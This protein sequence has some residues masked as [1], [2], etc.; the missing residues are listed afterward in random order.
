MQRKEIIGLNKK[1]FGRCNIFADQLQPGDLVRLAESL[2]FQVNKYKC[3]HPQT[4][5][6][7]ASW[8]NK[9]FSCN[10]HA[11][12]TPDSSSDNLEQGAARLRANWENLGEQGKM[13]HDDKQSAVNLIVDKL[14]PLVAQCP[15]LEGRPSVTAFKQQLRRTKGCAGIDGWSKNEITTVLCCDELVQELWD[16]MGE[17]GR[18]WNGS[19]TCTKHSCSLLGKRNGSCAEHFATREPPTHL[20]SVGLLEDVECNLVEIKIVDV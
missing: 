20:G 11:V 4:F 8:M 1:I 14:Y 16:E 10:A 15:K 2:E 5:S 9:K 6:A 18:Y 13:S 3:F 7:R 12:V 19:Y 17:L